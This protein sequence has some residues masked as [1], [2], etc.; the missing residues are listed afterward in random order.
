MVASADQWLV[1]AKN[2]GLKHLLV[3]D[4]NGQLYGDQL[5]AERLILSDKKMKIT[6]L[7]TL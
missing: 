3:M 6:I 2:T 4:K 5:F 1:I 7:G